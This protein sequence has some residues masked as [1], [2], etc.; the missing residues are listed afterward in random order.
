[1]TPKN[2][3][4]QSTNVMDAKT[5]TILFSLHPQSSKWWWMGVILKMRLPRVRPAE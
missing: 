4:M 2:A 3:T 1:M 5:V